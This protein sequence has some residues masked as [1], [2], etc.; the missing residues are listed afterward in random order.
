MKNYYQERTGNE[1]VS[2]VYNYKM[3]TRHPHFRSG[4][5]GMDAYNEAGNMN[6]VIGYER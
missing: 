2:T 5:W 1:V 3:Q 6:G 4:F